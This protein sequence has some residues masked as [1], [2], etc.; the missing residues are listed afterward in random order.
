MA[1]IAVITAIVQVRRLRQDLGNDL[2]RVTCE[3]GGQVIFEP[4]TSGSAVRCFA[5]CVLKG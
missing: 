3:V 2:P 4:G 5:F 1:G